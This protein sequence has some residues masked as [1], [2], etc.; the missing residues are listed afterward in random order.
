MA[1][2][3]ELFGDDLKQKKVPKVG[4]VR[5]VLAQN[6]LM[7]LILSNRT[8]KQVVDKMRHLAKVH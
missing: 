3:M 6:P 4:D 7:G 5:E 1:A 2:I 8:P